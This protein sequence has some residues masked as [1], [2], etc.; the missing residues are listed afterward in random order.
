MEDDNNGTKKK[1]DGVERV[2]QYRLAAASCTQ[3][4]HT[5]THT[6]LQWH[7]FKGADDA[8]GTEA[9]A[10]AATVS[11]AVAAAAAASEPPCACV[12]RARATPCRRR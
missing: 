1:T 4:E 3:L 2:S 11:V 10:A 6:D 7:T 12:L 9:A 5:H 8:R